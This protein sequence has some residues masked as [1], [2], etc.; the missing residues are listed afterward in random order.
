MRNVDQ[1]FCC[2]VIGVTRPT[3]PTG[4]SGGP[5]GH[6]E[7]KEYRVQPDQSVQRDDKETTSKL[8]FFLVILKIIL[9]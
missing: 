2:S 9:T 3:G 6:K 4:P 5:T 1:I 7:S 8:I